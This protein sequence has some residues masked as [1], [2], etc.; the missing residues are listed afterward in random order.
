MK[1]E[2][3]AQY[4]G[5]C[6]G[7]V[8]KMRHRKKGRKLGVN[9]KHRRAMLR[10][11][12]ANLF[13]HE[14][15]KTTDTK[16]KELRSFAE[17]VITLAKEDTL[18]ARRHVLRILD[19]KEAMRK[20]FSEIAPRYKNRPGGYTRI[21]K[22]GMRR[23]DNAPLSQVELVEEGVERKPRKKVKKRVEEQQVLPPPP[24]EEA[25][26][27]SQ[28]KEAAEELGLAP[29]GNKENEDKEIAEESEEKKSQEDS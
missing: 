18:H 24:K 26:V 7:E 8:L 13:Q 14:S 15:I 10:N 28:K 19:N 12:A 6:P 25:Q 20:L 9:T 4:A 5:L 16:A 22:I 21:V 11:L 17:K 1:V 29:V 23:G 2:V 3:G 27:K